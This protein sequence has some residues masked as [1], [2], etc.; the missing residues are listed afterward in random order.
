MARSHVFDMPFGDQGLVMPRRT[1]S[2]LGGF[3]ASLICGEDHEFIWRARHN[4]IPVQP[5]DAMLL[6]SARRYAQQGWWKTTRWSIAETWR[7]TRRFSR[8]CEPK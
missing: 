7:Q 1:F 3:N 2:Q 8:R 6:T 5:V 4:R